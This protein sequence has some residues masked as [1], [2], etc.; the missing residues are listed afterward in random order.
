MISMD[1]DTD[2]VDAVGHVDG[3]TSS[4]Q[5]RHLT[6]EADALNEL[7]SIAGYCVSVHAAS[8]RASRTPAPGPST[9]I[10]STV[11]PAENT[12]LVITGDNPPSGCFAH[13]SRN[14][15]PAARR[16]TCKNVGVLAN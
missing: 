8:Q 13:C 16:Q 15:A 4:Q 11:Q 5:L 12:Y 6:T 9:D 1:L 10:F 2:A 7:A 14:E 3:A